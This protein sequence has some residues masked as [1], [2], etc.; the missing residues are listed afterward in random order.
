MGKEA[1]LGD[2]GPGFEATAKIGK[3]ELMGKYHE[4]TE[5]LM[6]PENYKTTGITKDYSDEIVRKFLSEK[7]EE[8]MD[9]N[10]PRPDVKRIL[11]LEEPE[12]KW[13]EEGTVRIPPKPS[14]SGEWCKHIV[15]DSK[16]YNTVRNGPHVDYGNC[17]VALFCPACA[18]PRP[19]VKTRREQ[20][21]KIL[22]QLVIYVSHRTECQFHGWRMKENVGLTHK[23]ATDALSSLGPEV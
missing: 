5:R 18:A 8:L 10:N 21:E 19:K 7:A 13:K 1:R 12:K 6:F 3:G 9:E 4:L 14:E 15:L 2:L 22:D 16:G 11:G 20:I 23:Q 17:G